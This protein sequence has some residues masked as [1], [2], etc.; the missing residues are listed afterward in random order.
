[1]ATAKTVYYVPPEA[2]AEATKVKVLDG[3]PS[4]DGRLLV[5]LD[6]LNVTVDHQGTHQMGA[7]YWTKTKP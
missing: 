5:D 6:G 3:D 2:G 7:A 1:M 4:G